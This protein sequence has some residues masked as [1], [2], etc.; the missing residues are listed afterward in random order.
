[1]A[2]VPPWEA[3]ASAACCRS[4][5]L[6]GRKPANSKR[7]IGK[8]L[9]IRPVITELTPGM[10]AGSMPSARALR[11]RADPGSAS[12]GSPASEITATRFPFFTSSITSS[13]ALSSL[14]SFISTSFFERL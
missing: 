3:S 10:I 7:S 5:V 8:P 14:C 6:R 1:M 2:I 9:A 4:S 12:R 13:L 11:I